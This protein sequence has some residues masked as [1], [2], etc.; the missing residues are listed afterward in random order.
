LQRAARF[1]P[2]V[3][4]RT[5]RRIAMPGKAESRRIRLAA[6]KLTMLAELNDTE[7]ADRIWEALPTTARARSGAMRSTSRSR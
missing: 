6:G 4:L 5:W 3:P 1:I 2:A 7:T